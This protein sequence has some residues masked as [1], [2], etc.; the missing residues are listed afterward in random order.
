MKRPNMKRGIFR[1]WLLASICWSI[2]A[3]ARVFEN[4][5]LESPSIKWSFGFWELPLV[6]IFC[7]W[8]LTA[9]IFGCRWV[10][11]GFIDSDRT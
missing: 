11:R 10:Y 6:T 3:A 7:P 5:A 9:F 8:I 1:A 4:Q 2:Y